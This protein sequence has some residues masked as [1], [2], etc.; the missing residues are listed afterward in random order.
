MISAGH[1]KIFRQ[2]ID[3]QWYRDSNTKSL[4]LHCLLMA[5]WKDA[6]FMLTDVPRGSFI[7]SIDSLSQQTGLTPRQIRTSL[8]KLELSG[9]IIKKTTNKFT[10]INVVNYKLFQDENFQ[11]DK[12]MTNKRQTND[13]QMT[14]IEE[15]KER[16]NNNNIYILYGEFQNVKL[17]DAEHQKLVDEF[18][19][20]GT[21]EI[22]KI[23]DTYKGS[24][25]KKYKS[26]YLAIKN[27]VIDRYKNDLNKKNK[28]VSFMDIE[29]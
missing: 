18:G 5:N 7:T 27:W 8:K 28:N 19:N 17:T 26:D 6:K 24:S 3:W 23:L 14:T 20:D 15:Y 13:K 4:F 1:I 22:I 9:E 11:S 29:L 25:G 21:E 2:M 16:K 10:L 12:Q